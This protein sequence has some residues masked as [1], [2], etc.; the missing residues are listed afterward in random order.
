MHRL[1]HGIEDN[2]INVTTPVTKI[3]VVTKAYFDHIYKSLQRHSKEKTESAPWF[4]HFGLI[5]VFMS[6]IIKL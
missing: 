3:P 6:Y 1:K 4:G 5:Y 2:I